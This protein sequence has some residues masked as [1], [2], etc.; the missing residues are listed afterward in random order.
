MATALSATLNRPFSPC[1]RR[2]AGVR[3]K[4]AKTFYRRPTQKPLSRSV[5]HKAV[6]Q[7][8]IDIIDLVDGEM[9]QQGFYVS[10]GLSVVGFLGTFVFAPKYK[11]ELKEDF[12]WKEMC[13]ALR[14]S[15]LKSIEPTEA[16]AMQKKGAVL[17]DVRSPSDYNRGFIEDSLNMP[18]Y[19]A[20]QGWGV[21]ANV[22]RAA[23]AFFGIYGSE[24]DPE[25]L[26]E[27]EATVPKN[28]KVV[29]MCPRGGS[30]NARGTKF[31]FESRS[32]KAAFRLQNAG[33]TN[34]QHLKGGI[35][36][37]GRDGLPVFEYDE[38]DEE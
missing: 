33:Y 36:Q 34:V 37:W 12:S 3:H 17:V 11:D 1:V 21:A 13:L 16:L 27:M 35:S 30:I 38:E 5:Q 10:L 7:V 20:I 18:L 9:F 31:G 23:F 28:K 4:V 32:L 8:G 24:L 14:E 6:A 22:R 15:D 19:R 2:G 26:S 29:V 25:W